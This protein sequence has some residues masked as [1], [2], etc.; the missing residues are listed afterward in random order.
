MRITKKQMIKL[1]KAIKNVINWEVKKIILST[2]DAQLVLEQYKNDKKEYNK[3]LEEQIELYMPILLK[4]LII[5][6]WLKEQPENEDVKFIREMS[7][8]YLDRFLGSEEK[9]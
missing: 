4:N 9:R 1:K 2:N 8:E 5:T 3:K 7:F 6:L